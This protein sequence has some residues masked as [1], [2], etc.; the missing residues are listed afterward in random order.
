LVGC[1]APELWR[2]GCIRPGERA[3]DIRLAIRAKMDRAV[4]RTVLQ[5]KE[6]DRSK[7][8]R[9]DGTVSDTEWTAR[10]LHVMDDAPQALC[11][12]VRRKRVQEEEKDGEKD[13]RHRQGLQQARIDLKGEPLYA[14]DEES[15]V[16]GKCICRAIASGLDEQGFSDPEIVRRCNQRAD[17]SENRLKEAR[18]DFCAARL[19]CGD[20]YADALYLLLSCMACSLLALMRIKLSSQW[21]RVRAA[22]F[23]HRLHAMAGQAVS[24]GRQRFLKV[25]SGK[26]AGLEEA[27]WQIRAC[28][29]C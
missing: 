14:T 13:A 27:L 20:F 12:A 23:R 11:P 10:T 19:P 15:A 29:L 9:E 5:I 4:R 1:P 2:T 17:A 24:H 25:A 7:A 6:K 8:V 28:S 16:C 3:H 26:L 22:T 18:S 21:H